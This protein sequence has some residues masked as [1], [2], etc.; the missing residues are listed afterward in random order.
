VIV[1]VGQRRQHLGAQG[2]VLELKIEERDFHQDYL[3]TDYTD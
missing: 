3:T 2:L 1:G